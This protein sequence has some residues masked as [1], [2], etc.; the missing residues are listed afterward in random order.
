MQKVILDEALKAR[1]NGLNEHLEIQDSTGKVVGHYLP[2]EEYG[3]YR[4]AMYDM[5]K[6]ESLRQEA[7]D[8]ANGFVRKWDG[9][10]GMTTAQVLELFRRLDR[11]TA[12]GTSTSFGSTPS[13]TA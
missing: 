12:K 3:V 4:R 8:K 11:E 10:N 5:I 6:A 7:E 1:L 13:R 2:D 9:T